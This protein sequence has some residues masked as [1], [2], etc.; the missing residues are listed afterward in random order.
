MNF[1]L[2]TKWF[3]A[4]DA[5]VD[6]NLESCKEALQACFD[7]L[8][9]ERNQFYSV[10]SYFV[11]MTLCAS[12]VLGPSLA[13]ELDTNSISNFMISGEVLA[14]LAENNPENLER[15]K[16][17]FK[18]ESIGLIGGEYHEGTLPLQSPEAILANFQQ[19][20]KVYEQHLGKRPTVFGRRR[21]GLSSFLPQ[22]LSN[23]GYQGAFHLA[24]DEGS[25]PESSQSKVC[26]E[27]LDGSS[28]DAI[29]KPPIDAN[30]ADGFL[31]LFMRLGEAMD[32]EHVATVC[33]AHW[34]SMT[35]PWYEDL[36]RI[37]RY[38]ACL[39]KFVTV[40]QYFQET[41]IPPFHDNFSSN[42]YR[43][44]YFKQSYIKKQQDPDLHASSTKS[45]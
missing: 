8:A 6:G 26:W 1:I 18:D 29:A 3:E 22:L 44:P 30:K 45:I 23:L 42:N 14:E 10:D 15:L 11:D 41:V 31:G 4:A 20:H 40:E 9:E 17:K 16:Q 25:Y 35:C 13:Q 33:F 43:T 32:S 38:A 5:L 39:G 2:M 12:T 28:I 34:P 21:F 19:G 7:V 24:L 36:R 37:E 27:G